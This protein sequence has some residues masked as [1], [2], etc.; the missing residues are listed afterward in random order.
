ME[1]SPLSDINTKLGSFIHPWE[2]IVLKHFLDWLIPSRNSSLYP[3]PNEENFTLTLFI[4]SQ[5]YLASVDLFRIVCFM[6]VIKCYIQNRQ[7][8]D[9]AFN[10]KLWVYTSELSLLH[11]NILSAPC[12]WCGGDF[13]LKLELLY[14]PTDLEKNI[15]QLQILTEAKTCR[16]SS[17]YASKVLSSRR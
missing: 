12:W 16:Y 14:S 8:L 17:C 15:T 13:T 10:Y 3:V 5:W 9:N 1:H 11:C 6:W 4:L 7:E 2:E